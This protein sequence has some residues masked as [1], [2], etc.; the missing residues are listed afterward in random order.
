MARDTHAGTMQG[1]KRL[2]DS[3]SGKEADPATTNHPPEGQ[4]DHPARV[5][6]DW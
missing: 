2:I 4:E 5:R 1:W 6:H 3:I